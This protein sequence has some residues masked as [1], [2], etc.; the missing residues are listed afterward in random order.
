MLVP[1]A[2]RLAL[3]EH[4]ITVPSAARAASQGNNRPDHQGVPGYAPV[5]AVFATSEFPELPVHSVTGADTPGRTLSHSVKQPE[6]GRSHG[7]KL[8]MTERAGVCP[9]FLWTHPRLIRPGNP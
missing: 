4:P 1:G 6:C 8:L 5:I 3:G 2:D 7:A 9:R